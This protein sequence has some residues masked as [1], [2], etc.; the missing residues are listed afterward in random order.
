MITRLSVVGL[1]FSAGLI[2]GL[3]LSGRA[4]NRDDIVTLPPSTAAPAD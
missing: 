2:A 4:V 3:V 1:L